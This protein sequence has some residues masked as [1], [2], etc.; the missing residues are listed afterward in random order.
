MK[1]EKHKSKH[2]QKQAWEITDHRHQ[3]GQR[4][5]ATTNS[6]AAAV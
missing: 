3:E 4:R 5:P 2:K 6:T 1:N